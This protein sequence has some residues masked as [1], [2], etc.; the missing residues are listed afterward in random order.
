[1]T[2][3]I[4]LGLNASV[5]IALALLHFSWAL[6]NEW[7]FD[8]ALPKKENGERLMTPRKVDSF[9]VGIGL[10]GIAVYYLAM[11]KWIAL[12]LPEWLMNYGLWAIAAIFLLRAIGEFRYVGLFKK[13]TTTDFARLDTRLYSPLCLFLSF[14][15]FYLILGVA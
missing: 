14:S 3:M 7:G 8:A 11:G 13:I 1:M 9:I 2:S 5:F 15:A 6:G 4:I 10:L 12:G